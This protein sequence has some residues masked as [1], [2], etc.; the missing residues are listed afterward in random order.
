[1]RPLQSLCGQISREMY[2]EE[3]VKRLYFPT[4]LQNSLKAEK[5][6]NLRLLFRLSRYVYLSQPSFG[7]KI[8]LK[9][10]VKAIKSRETLV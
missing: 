6:R 7:A 2:F 3:I 10:H 9:S 4:N 5:S 1:M 8:D